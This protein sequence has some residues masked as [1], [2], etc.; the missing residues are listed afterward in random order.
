MLN[1][2]QRKKIFK[3]FTTED[4]QYLEYDW[5]FWARPKQ[6]TPSSDDWIIWLILAGRGFGKTRTGAEFVRQQVYQ[7]KKRIALIAPT[8]AD[9]RDIM[10]NGKSGLMNIFPP[11]EKPIYKPSERKIIFHTGAIATAFSADEP[12]R[13]RG[14][15]HDCGWMDELSSFRYPIDAY[16]MFMFGLR[17]G[18]NPNAIITT[19]PKNIPII[20]QLI[21]DEIVHVTSGST[22]DNKSNLPKSFLQTVKTKYEHTTIGR[23]ELY[24]EI[25][26]DVEGALWTNAIIESNRIKDIDDIDFARIVIGVDPA[27]S[28]N[29]NSDETGIIVAAMDYDGNGY[30]LADLSRRYKP[31]EWATVVVNLF[32]RYHAD[33][34][35]PEVNQGGDMVESTIHSIDATV[36]IN[37]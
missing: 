27:I 28:S 23:Q 5:N 21:K 24:A 26:D 18:N 8:S 17:L 35:V 31:S 9:T 34:I 16:D 4:Y 36:P 10:I 11:K 6:V 1:P 20:K 3:G 37:K 29:D 32:Y 30:I 7:G 13:L 22:F 15:E 2:N 33:R 14:Y 25:L 19:T 12:D